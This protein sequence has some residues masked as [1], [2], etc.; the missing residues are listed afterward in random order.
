[1]SLTGPSKP[2]LSV[3]PWPSQV[4]LSAAEA[5]FQG[6]TA[7]QWTPSRFPP[8]PLLPTQ[9]WDEPLPFWR[10]YGCTW[11]FAWPTLFYLFQ[12]GKEKTCIKPG[13]SIFCLSISSANTRAGTSCN[14]YVYFSWEV[15]I[16][17]L[18]PGSQPTGVPRLGR[19]NWCIRTAASLHWLLQL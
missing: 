6:S 12:R 8:A 19:V 4:C 17:V 14:Q 10:P 18:S 2:D 5:V 16:A 1:M 9:S 15:G 3:T 11:L 13:L 7:T